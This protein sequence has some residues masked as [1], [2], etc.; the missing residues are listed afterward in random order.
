F[1]RYTGRRWIAK[2]EQTRAGLDEQAVGMAVVAAFKLDDFWPTGGPARQADGAHGG[3]GSGTD[4]AHLLHGRHQCGDSFGK[5]DFAF[6]GG[7]KRQATAGGVLDGLD[8]VRVGMTQDGRTPRADVINV[9]GV[10]GI[11]DMGAQCPLNEYRRASDRS[12][13]TDG[14]VDPTG[15]GLACA[16]KKF[17]VTAHVGLIQKERKVMRNSV[18]KSYCAT[19]NCWQ[20][21]ARA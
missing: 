6:R 20:S 1:F 21:W 2:R 3:L 7:A 4:Q 10:V 5:F 15:Y 14:G 12:E 16:F 19:N 18:A 11:P 8:D 13:G 17:S 9:L